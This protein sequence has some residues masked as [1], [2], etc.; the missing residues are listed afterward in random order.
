MKRDNEMEIVGKNVGYKEV[1]LSQN[2]RISYLAKKVIHTFM[3]HEAMLATVESCTGGWL[4]SSI[5]GIHGASAIFERG[6]VVYSNRAKVEM[7]GID[8]KWLVKYGAVSAEV[9]EV[10]ALGALEHSDADV[11]IAITGIAGPSGGSNEKPVGLVYHCCQH[12]GQIPIIVRN[13]FNGDR[14]SI[15]RQSVMKGL[16][17]LLQAMV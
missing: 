9:A 2:E 11:S 7:L 12:R 13:I 1:G 3:T 10:M 5:T 4:S 15:R 14:E 16:D 6:F 8:E 17:L